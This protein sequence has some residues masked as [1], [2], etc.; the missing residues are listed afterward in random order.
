MNAQLTQEELQQL[1]DSIE[2]YEVVTQASPDDIHS[3]EI[4]RESYDRLGRLDDV[5][6]VTRKLIQALC[7]MEQFPQALQECEFALTLQPDAPDIIALQGELEQHLGS[8]P[9]QIDMEEQA[10]PLRTIP[11]P[12][13]LPQSSPLKTQETHQNNG[14]PML[15]PGPATIPVAVPEMSYAPSPPSQSAVEGHLVKRGGT[16]NIDIPFNTGEQS[17]HLVETINTGGGLP[18][19]NPATTTS[20]ESDGTEKLATFLLHRGLCDRSALEK[21]APAVIDYN[22]MLTSD[23]MGA[24]LL[25]ELDRAGLIDLDKILLNIVEMVNFGFVPLEFYEGDRNT[26]RLLPPELSLHRMVVPFEV[27]SRCVMIA[28]CN[29]VDGGA[30]EAI[31]QS[32]DY[33]VQW[34]IARPASIAKQLSYAFGVDAPKALV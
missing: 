34:F 28:T 20:L 15:I 24:S 11:A 13:D 6:R 22:R 3:L 5:T 27:I 16:S 17:G 19:V 2:M 18:R 8:Q 23:Q 14:S 9:A 26:M 29:H 30:K 21:V 7:H 25:W 10:P 4:L 31:Q 1:L 33:H 32:L 12:S